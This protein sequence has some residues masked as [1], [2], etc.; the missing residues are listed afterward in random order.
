MAAWCPPEASKSEMNKHKHD[1][2]DT[3]DFTIFFRVDGSFSGSS[4]N[5]S[6][7]DDLL[8]NYNVFFLSDLVA[9]SQGV[10]VFPQSANDTALTRPSTDS[11][12]S[13]VG[14]G[15]SRGLLVGGGC[16]S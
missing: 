4:S 10:D 8:Y 16:F 11:F 6:T 9:Y 12:D 5:F 13:V 7:G 3:G 1:L 14:S 15:G 2:T